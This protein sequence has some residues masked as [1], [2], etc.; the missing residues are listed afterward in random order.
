MNEIPQRYRLTEAEKEAQ[1][2]EAERQLLELRS[3]HPEC[4]EM[5]DEAIA[6]LRGK[7]MAE[8]A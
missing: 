1:I 6:R 3:S 8:A 2:A 4:A 7:V 5:C